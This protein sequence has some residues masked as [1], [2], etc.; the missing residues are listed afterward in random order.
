M[1]RLFLVMWGQWLSLSACLP[2]WSASSFIR[3]EIASRNKKLHY[4]QLSHQTSTRPHHHP[5]FTVEVAENKQLDDAFYLFASPGPGPVC[6]KVRSKTRRNVYLWNSFCWHRTWYTGVK[7]FL[8]ISACTPVVARFMSESWQSIIITP[9]AL[10]W[11]SAENTEHLGQCI[12]GITIQNNIFL[13]ICP[14]NQP[15]NSLR[16]QN[17]AEIEGRGRSDETR[18]STLLTLCCR[19]GVFSKRYPGL[20][21][22]FSV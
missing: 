6:L 2:L 13:N 10:I 3:Q 14:S 12:I 19:C 11:A 16:N 5:T 18:Q 1:T 4:D 17:K 21:T 20:V 9:L 15:T 22:T 7:T 8:S